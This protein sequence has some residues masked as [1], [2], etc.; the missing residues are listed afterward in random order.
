MRLEKKWYGCARLLRRLT[1]ALILLIALCA[2]SCR[3][4]KNGTGLPLPKPVERTKLIPVYVPPD[5]AW[6]RAYLECDSNNQVILKAFLEQKS[7]DVSSSLKLDSGILDYKAKAVHDTIRIV[8]KDSLIYIPHDVPGPQVN[9]LTWWQQF[10]MKTG[11]LSVLILALWLL[12][13]LMKWIFK[14]LKPRLNRI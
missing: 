13:S 5:S 4:Q 9:V 2:G 10:W 14:R 11:K 12:P 8:G 7:G 1:P 3:T 6:L